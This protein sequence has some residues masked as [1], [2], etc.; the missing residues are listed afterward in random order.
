VSELS[1]GGNG[2]DE[3]LMWWVS[4]AYLHPERLPKVE[5]PPPPPPKKKRPRDFTMADLPTQCA[6]VLASD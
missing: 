2:C 6:A 3:T 4:D 5:N 1:K